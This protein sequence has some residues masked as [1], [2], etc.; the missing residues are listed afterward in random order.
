[1][2]SITVGYKSNGN[3]Y[4]L[5]FTVH[6]KHE[7]VRITVVDWQLWKIELCGF[8]AFIKQKTDDVLPEFILFNS[9]R[10]KYSYRVNNAEYWEER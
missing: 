9:R 4:G 10:G 5:Y 6:N 1:M 7:P 3:F 8:T 2:K